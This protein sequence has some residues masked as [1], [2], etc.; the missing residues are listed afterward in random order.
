MAGTCVCVFCDS[1]PDFAESARG[2]AAISHEQPS[3]HSENASTP[4]RG[5]IFNNSY[6]RNKIVKVIKL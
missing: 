6:K 1:S 5:A 2:W 4:H 3:V